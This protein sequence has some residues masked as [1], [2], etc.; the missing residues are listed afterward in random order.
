MCYKRIPR[1]MAYCSATLRLSRL[2]VLAMIMTWLAE[3]SARAEG[4]CHVKTRENSSPWPSTRSALAWRILS[5]TCSV[6]SWFTVGPLSVRDPWSG[7]CNQVFHF[8]SVCP[9]QASIRYGGLPH[10]GNRGRGGVEKSNAVRPIP[11]SGTKEPNSQVMKI[12]I[13]TWRNTS[14]EP[15][16]RPV[17]RRA[18]NFR[19]SQDSTP[20]PK[21]FAWSGHFHVAEIAWDRGLFSGRADGASC[22]VI[23]HPPMERRLWFPLTEST[24]QTRWSRGTVNSTRDPGLGAIQWVM[25]R[26]DRFCWPGDER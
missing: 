25:A 14:E 7:G 24:R 17:T 1:R 13:W 16:C 21:P 4:K 5:V 2:F 22:S 9:V 26:S 10:G 11:E 23:N 19:R 15:K 8:L 3:I 12:T 20:D 6:L 18:R